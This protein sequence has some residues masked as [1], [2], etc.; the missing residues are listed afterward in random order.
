MTFVEKEFY[1]IP[2][3]PDAPVSEWE[4]WMTREK[5][6]RAAHRAQYTRSL[7]VDP[8]G[9][10]SMF[11]THDAPVKVN[12]VYRQSEA[13]VGFSGSSEDNTL[14]FDPACHQNQEREI[15]LAEMETHRHTQGKTSRG[16]KSRQNRLR[17][18]AKKA[19]RLELS[20]RNLH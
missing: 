11:H 16:K 2:P 1:H 6:A 13:F 7:D 17:R 10:E 8:E 15:Y 5:R 9:F 14:D 19:R 20:K 18:A 3:A 12:G 4:S